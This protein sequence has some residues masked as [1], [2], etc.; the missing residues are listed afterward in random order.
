MQSPSNKEINKLKSEISTLKDFNVVIFR[1]IGDNKKDIEENKKK[2]E[3]NKKEN[4]NK[5][6]ENKNRIMIAA[7]C[8]NRGPDNREICEKISK[9]GGIK[10][11]KRKSRKKKRKTNKKRKRNKKRKT[12]RKKKK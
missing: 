10:K 2:I 1:K 11:K 3:K 5:I 12:K 4:K 7:D 8:G 9:G 6:E